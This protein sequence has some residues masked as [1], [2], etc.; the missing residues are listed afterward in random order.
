MRARI[1]RVSLVTIALVAL[2][3][4]VAC[5]AQPTANTTPEDQ[6]QEQPADDQQTDPTDETEDPA[7]QTDDPAAEPEPG[8]PGANDQRD[9]AD[10]PIATVSYEKNGEDQTTQPMACDSTWSFEQDG[11]TMTVTTEAPHPVEYDAEGMPAVSVAD[12][13]KVSVSFDVPAT[14]VTVRSWSEMDILGSAAP[15]NGDAVEVELADDGSASFTVMP[16]FRYA[17]NATFDAGEALY[18]FTVPSV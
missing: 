2:L 4:T 13:T 11:E 5:N 12:P 15:L 10:P 8:D 7:A 16:G 18:V 14:G 9:P 17:V 1:G 3:G 6:Q